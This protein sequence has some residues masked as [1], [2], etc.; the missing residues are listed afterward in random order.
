MNKFEKIE[1]AIKLL[2]QN[3][4]DMKTLWKPTLLHSIRVGM[5]LL[6]DWYEENIVL[7]GLLHDILEDTSIDV[8]EVRS[9]FGQKVIDLIIAN[10]KNR[11]LPKDQ[12]D[13]DLFVRCLNHWKDAMIIKWYDILDNYKYFFGET[14]DIQ[15]QNRI[16]DLLKLFV[17]Y[18]PKDYNENIF[19][20]LRDTYKVFFYS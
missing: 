16:L 19:K 13:E 8:N 11:E 5:N 2:A 15:K 9:I 3:M 20:K 12:I 14:K 18:L 7:A 1:I 6:E 10:S 4:W 17:K